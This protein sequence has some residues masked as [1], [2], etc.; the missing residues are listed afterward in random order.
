MGSM[1]GGAVVKG[2]LMKEC[3]PGSSMR[4]AN[5]TQTGSGPRHTHAQHITG[6]YKYSAAHHSTAQR[7]TAQHS[8]RLHFGEGSVNAPGRR[9]RA[10]GSVHI[11]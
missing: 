4:T 11:P 6:Q 5:T 2:W 7:S 9:Q 1:S 8:Q 3:K 10:C